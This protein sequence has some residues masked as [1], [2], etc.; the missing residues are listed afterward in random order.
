MKH[1]KQCAICGKP[2]DKA[3]TTS[4]SNWHK[5]ESCGKSCS[6]MLAKKR[7]DAKEAMQHSATSALE[8]VIRNW[9]T[10]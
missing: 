8:S 3:A 1:T 2:F 4:M 6:V 9:R 7:I 5:K 10:A